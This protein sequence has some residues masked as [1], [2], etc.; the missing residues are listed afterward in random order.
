LH[1]YSLAIADREDVN[2]AE[3]ILPDAS[4]GIPPLDYLD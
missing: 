4:V 1:C 2:D 3:K